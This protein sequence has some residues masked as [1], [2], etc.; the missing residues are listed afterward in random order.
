MPRRPLWQIDMGDGT[1][2]V[3]CM[4]C[5]RPLY[6]GAKATANRVARRHRCEPVAPRTTRRRPR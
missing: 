2:S 6:R 4:T 1:W 3:C 5:C